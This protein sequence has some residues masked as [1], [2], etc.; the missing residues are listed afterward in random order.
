[1]VQLKQNAR[2][3]LRSLAFFLIKITVSVRFSRSKVN[4]VNLINGII[5]RVK[6]T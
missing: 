4:Y 1:L 6:E 2:N 5:V 3:T